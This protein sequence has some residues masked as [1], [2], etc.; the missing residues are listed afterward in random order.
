VREAQGKR[1]ELGPETAPLS[2]T[3]D[4]E[5]GEEA[6]EGQEELPQPPAATPKAPAPTDRAC[7]N[8]TAA[9]ASRLP[10][11]IPAAPH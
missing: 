6:G 5:S 7:C 10:R 8:Q 9:P 1:T 11:F 4:L 3:P 2:P